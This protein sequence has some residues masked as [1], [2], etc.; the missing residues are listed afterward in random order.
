MV[1]INLPSGLRYQVLQPPRWSARGPYRGDTVAISY[2][3]WMNENGEPGSEVDQCEDLSFVVARGHIMPGIDEGVLTMRLGEK[4][5]LYIPADLA[6]QPS[7]GHI[8]HIPQGDLIFDVM[9]QDIR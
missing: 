6:Q 8:S 7:S 1:V 3:G 9:L 4:R 2:V 5:R